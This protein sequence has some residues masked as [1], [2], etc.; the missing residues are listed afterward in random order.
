MEEVNDDVDEL[1]DD[2]YILVSNQFFVLFFG[3]SVFSQAL[4]VERPFHFQAGCQHCF[5]DKEA[6]GHFIA[7]AEGCKVT[8][9]HFTAAGVH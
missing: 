1:Q 4:G 7:G 3:F 9:W 6:E 5:R 8:H 2:D